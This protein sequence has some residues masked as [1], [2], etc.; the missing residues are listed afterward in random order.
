M[1]WIDKLERRFG[2]FAV[3]NMMLYL[4]IFYVAGFLIS[5]VNPYFYY[6]HLSLN[7]SMILRGQIWRLATFLMAPP[8]T[9]ILWLALLSFIYYNLGRS[10]ERL[11]GTF[12]VNLY[13]LIGILGYILAAFIIHFVWRL[14]YPLTAD[15]LYMTI[16]LAFA[17]TVPE[18]QFYLYF[19]IPIKAKWIGIF[20]L[21][22]LGLE[23]ISA[24]G[25]GRVAII[26][27]IL[28]FILFFFT[29]H[30]PVQMAKQAK[31]R[32]DFTEKMRASSM[33]PERSIHRCAV[34]GRTEKDNPD[35]EFRYC[36]KC[37]GNLEYCQDHLYTHVHVTDE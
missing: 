18:T 28:N 23:F 2:R 12:R 9:N 27:S 32:H 7:V 6:Q 16:I 1:N 14:D 30:P 8:T 10:L 37:K 15:S 11:W 29:G 35:L 4:I 17:M 13:L 22:L 36:S 5:T 34:C 20:D 24:S 33:N 25:P 19:A 26:M 21:V 31:R 3:R